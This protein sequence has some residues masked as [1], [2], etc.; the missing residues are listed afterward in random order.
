MGPNTRRLGQTYR[1]IAMRNSVNIA[2]LIRHADRLPV[3]LRTGKRLCRAGMQVA[4]FA[5][6][7]CLQA[8]DESAWEHMACRLQ[9]NTERCCSHSADG[10]GFDFD[11]ASLRQMGKKIAG[12][13][14]VISF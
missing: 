7:D 5:S 2:V 12:A 1:T 14:L 6:G 11:A 9:M 4:I 3:A 13:D 8:F 10:Q